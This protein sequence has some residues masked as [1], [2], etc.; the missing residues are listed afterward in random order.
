MAQKRGSG[1]KAVEIDESWMGRP[2]GG[3][4]TPDGE[5]EAAVFGAKVYAAIR[6]VERECEFMDFAVYR[7]RVF[8]GKSG[9]DVAE[10]LGTSEP[11][12]SRKLAKVREAMRIRLKDVVLTYSFTDDEL[13]EP[14]RKGLTLA[15]NK[16]DD[17]LFDEAMAEIYSRQMEIIA[18][19]GAQSPR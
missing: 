13:S 8:D 16:D 11:T 17:A 1:K 6:L 3:G 14:E 15:P 19:D 4:P 7:M 12:V 10:A 2:P 18:R 5:Y 9:K